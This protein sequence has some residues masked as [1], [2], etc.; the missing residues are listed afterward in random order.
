MPN[1]SSQTIRFQRV[2]VFVSVAL[3][4]IKMLAWILTGSVAI[5][6]D[7][8]ESTVNVVAGFI[9]LYSIILSAKPKDK[10][11]PYGHGKV[12][13]ISS[14]IEGIL[15]SIAGLVIIYEAIR[16]LWNPHELKQLSW[17]L[18]LVAFSAIIN[19][20]VGHICVQKGRKENSPILIAS[21]SHLKSDTYSSLGLIVGIVL[22]LVTGFHWIDSIAALVFACIIILTGYKIIRKS[23]SGMMDEIDTEIVKEIVTVLNKHRDTNWI[24][25][26][27]MRVIDYA[28]FYHIDCHL[29]VPYYINIDEGHEILDSLTDMLKEHFK[30]K[31]EFFVHIDGC[32]QTQCSLCSIQPCLKRSASFSKQLIWTEEMILS[33]QKHH[34]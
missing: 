25:I 26:H 20:V 32:I 30:N 34:L 11:H 22:L 17:G 19:F 4:V 33:N 5:L 29:T 14:A 9:G 8:L 15:I 2:L 18:I 13:F 31:V 23:V 28:G 1:S 24:D 12:E 27:N 7:A 16:N 21:G 6:T 10:E 3:F